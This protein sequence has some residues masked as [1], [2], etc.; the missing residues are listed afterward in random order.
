M[1]GSGLQRSVAAGEDPVASVYAPRSRLSVILPIVI[2]HTALL[3]LVAINHSGPA[4]ARRGD[5]TLAVF[6]VSI[7][8]APP[9][10]ARPLV[11]PPTVPPPLVEL[12]IPLPQPSVPA[13]IAVAAEL[14][15]V[16]SGG[17]DL[18]DVVQVALRESPT[19]HAAIEALPVKDRSVANAVM[20]WDGNWVQMTSPT[21]RDALT[22]IRQIVAQTIAAATPDCR[23]QLQAGPRLIAIPGQTDVTLA[24]GSG[25]W[26]W[27]DL[28]TTE[29]AQ[30]EP[31]RAAGNL[32]M[33]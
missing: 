33:N 26:R 29:I 12:P 2:I 10:K 3:A 7:P 22:T 5:A 25:R 30:G 16:P 4:T 28:A 15:A 21:A 24:L 8:I 11:K 20:I 14:E 18:T 13:P 19:A 27:D 1:S 9:A 17:C 6:D 23:S 32:A 31:P